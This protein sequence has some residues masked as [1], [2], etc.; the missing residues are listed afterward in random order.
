MARVKHY[1]RPKAVRD[2]PH[3]PELAGEPPMRGDPVEHPEYGLGTIG[4]VEWRGPE[5]QWVMPLERENAW[6]QWIA[7]VT[8]N[9]GGYRCPLE[10]LSR[11]R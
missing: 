5:G 8:T 11:V 3:T 7:I 6:G 4:W 2:H 10:E 1:R 9:R